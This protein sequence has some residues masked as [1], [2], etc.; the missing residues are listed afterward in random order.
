[1]GHDQRVAP[2]REHPRDAHRHCDRTRCSRRLGLGLEGAHVDPVTAREGL[3]RLAAALLA[4]T[5]VAP[6]CHDA[7][8]PRATAVRFSTA[9][10]T[11]GITLDQTTGIVPDG[12][13]WPA[14]GTHVGKDFPANPHLGDAIVATF[15]WRGTT[16]TI[17]SV[18]DHFCD[19]NSTP[20]GNTY[21][22]VDY[23]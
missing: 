8:G 3:A 15:F 5:F 19:V 20:I 23:V 4:V 18:S 7:A 13:A 1:S 21:T 22:L 16:N 10:S 14:G 17:T 9:A 12:E 11:T 6:A 2:L